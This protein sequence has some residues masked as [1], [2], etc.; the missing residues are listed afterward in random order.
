MPRYVV[1]DSNI[2]PDVINVLELIVKSIKSKKKN[3][4]RFQDFY[5]LISRVVIQPKKVRSLY[6]KCISLVCNCI[7]NQQFGEAAKLLWIMS[8]EKAFCDHFYYKAI[9]IVF[10]NLQLTNKNELI[11]TFVSDAGRLIL[12]N[13]KE[14]QLEYIIYGLKNNVPD[15]RLESEAIVTKRMKDKLYKNERLDPILD[16][17][18]NMIN[19]IDW[20]RYLTEET[21]PELCADAAE[22]AIVNL[23][24]V[25]KSPGQWD[26]FVLKIIEMLIYYEKHDEA[27]TVLLT[28]LTW[29]PKHINCYIY[30]CTYL[31]SYHPDSP[32]LMKNLEV[33]AQLCPSDERVLMLIEKR[34]LLGKKRKKNLKY[35]FMFLDYPS[36]AN[37]IKAW[38]LI[39]NVLHQAVSSNKSSALKVIKSSWQLRKTYWNYMYFN[40]SKLHENNEI[41]ICKIQVLKILEPGHPFVEAFQECC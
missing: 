12:I 7:Q 30:L 23:M 8:Q 28:Y 24:N 3:V 31:I 25:I 36:N 27:E 2:L 1:P 19:Y 5:T 34:A 37:N 22:R 38:Q 16:A 33:L 10:E 14:I 41:N 20:C 21:T 32:L 11:W 39:A 6:K 29:N 17:Y 26:I 4:K 15:L 18:S 9:M 40:V 13:K 35:I